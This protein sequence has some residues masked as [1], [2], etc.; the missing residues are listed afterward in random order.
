MTAM[1]KCAEAGSHGFGEAQEGKPR[2]AISR[3]SVPAASAMRSRIA[4]V[5]WW[6]LVKVVDDETADEGGGQ[7]AGKNAGPAEGSAESEFTAPAGA[8]MR[9]VAWRNPTTWLMRLMAIA[10]DEEEEEKDAV[11]GLLKVAGVEALAARKA[12]RSEKRNQAAAAR[13]HTSAERRW[14]K[15]TRLLR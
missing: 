10:G 7:N 3:A 1:K 6:V 11:E 9:A 13:N 15:L 12:T 4:T 2:K 8:G 5:N 14:R